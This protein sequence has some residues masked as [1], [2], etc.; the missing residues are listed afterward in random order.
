MYPIYHIDD[1]GEHMQ[2]ER[3]E[4]ERWRE[5]GR[6]RESKREMER[7]REREISV[8]NNLGQRQ[9]RGQVVG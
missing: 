9:H 8:A 4:R 6:E 5:E 1:S 2:E 3:G 7:E